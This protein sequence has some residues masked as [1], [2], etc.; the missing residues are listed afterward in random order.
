MEKERSEFAYNWTIKSGIHTSVNNLDDIGST[1]ERTDTVLKAG[2][3]VDCASQ[4]IEPNLLQES[5]LST[6]SLAAVPQIISIQQQL[7]IRNSRAALNR[8]TLVG[9]SRVRNTLVTHDRN[10][11]I[12]RRNMRMNSRVRRN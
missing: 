9:A 6:P 11:S 7:E 4:K 8:R 10:S 12:G 2:Q 5:S 3:E 1:V